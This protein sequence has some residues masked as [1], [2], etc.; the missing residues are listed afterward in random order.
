MRWTQKKWTIIIISLAGNY[1]SV[2]VNNCNGGVVV[3]KND[4]NESLLL[5]ETIIMPGGSITFDAQQID[6][7][8]FVLTQ[9][10]SNFSEYVP[11][12]DQWI[13]VPG[14]LGDQ[15]MEISF[16]KPRHC[17]NPLPEVVESKK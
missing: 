3:I 7:G 17:A 5:G 2:E 9:I 14:K 16:F 4:W 11:E 6:E 8:Q 1:L 15:T 13:E 12:S 10:P